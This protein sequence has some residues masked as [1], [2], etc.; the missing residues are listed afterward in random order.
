VDEDALDK[1]RETLETLV[2]ESPQFIEAQVTLALV[3]YLLKCPTTA[4]ARGKRAS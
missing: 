3:D 1:V 4:I 2:K